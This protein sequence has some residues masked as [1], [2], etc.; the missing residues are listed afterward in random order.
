M[1][2]KN[3]AL[4]EK[5]DSF[6]QL[7]NLTGYKFVVALQKNK[8][9]MEAEIAVLSKIAEESEEMK[10]IRNQFHQKQLELADKDENKQPVL[11]EDKQNIVIS[12]TNKV[13]LEKFANKLEKDN[14]ELLIVQKTKEL[15]LAKALDEDCALEFYK[16]KESAVPNNVTVEQFDIISF[17]VDL[18]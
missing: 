13:K 2:L 11:T 6:G 17:M 8:I 9:L 10:E 7:K 12:K 15:E 5:L 14:K 16:I 1:T 4:K 18:N 3:Y